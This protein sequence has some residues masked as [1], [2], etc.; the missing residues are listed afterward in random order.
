MISSHLLLLS[1]FELTEYDRILRYLETSTDA[2]NY[3]KALIES[4]ATKK[5]VN[6]S[7][8]SNCLHVLALK[9]E[10]F[11]LTGAFSKGASA[12]N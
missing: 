12:F 6:H 9:A 5:D 2:N 7:V 3:L 1:Y 8:A 4:I 10:C 11:L